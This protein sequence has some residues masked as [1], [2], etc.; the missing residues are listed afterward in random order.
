MPLENAEFSI[1]KKGGSIVYEGMT[2]KSGQIRV[3]DLA[4][5]WYTIT[6]LA[7]LSGYLIA[8]ESKDVYLEPN[9]T[10]EVK[11]D[12]RLRPSLQIMKL[13]SQTQEPLWQVQRS[14]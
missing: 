3:E 14:K 10:A 5:G 11:F 12:N 9:E 1:A 13:D 4:E 8:T 7:A 2:E 6:E